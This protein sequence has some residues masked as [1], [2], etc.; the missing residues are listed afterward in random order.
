MELQFWPLLQIRASEQTLWAP[1]WAQ[2]RSKL[3]CWPRQDPLSQR[4][5]NSFQKRWESFPTRLWWDWMTKATFCLA[6]LVYSRVCRSVLLTLR[7]SELKKKCELKRI[8]CIMGKCPN[9]QYET[10]L[11]KLFSNWKDWNRFIG[12]IAGNYFVP[13][14]WKHPHTQ[15]SAFFTHQYGFPFFFCLLNEN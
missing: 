1:K 9:V 8:D 2:L 10:N 7:I 6:V 4:K 15:L 14:I 3:L 12:G 11:D 13:G 5:E